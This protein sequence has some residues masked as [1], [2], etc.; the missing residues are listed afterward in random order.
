MPPPG[1]GADRMLSGVAVGAGVTCAEGAR[2]KSPARISA[3]TVPITYS[4][5]AIASP[6]ETPDPGFTGTGDAEPG[7]RAERIGDFQWHMTAEG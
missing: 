1:F 7:R 2:P 4:L 5:A 3:G 6:F